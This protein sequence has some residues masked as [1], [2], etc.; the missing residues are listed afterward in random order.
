MYKRWYI[1]NNILFT[2]WKWVRILDSNIKKKMK[3]FGIRNSGG[4]SIER[5]NYLIGIDDSKSI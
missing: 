1:E 3:V 2:S 4:L 5:I